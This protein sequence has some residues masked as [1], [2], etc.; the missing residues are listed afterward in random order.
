MATVTAQ[1]WQMLFHHG[2][3]LACSSFF[4][5][6]FYQQISA[7]FVDLSIPDLALGIACLVFAVFMLFRPY[8]FETRTDVFAL[9]ICGL[10]KTY[11]WLFD[12]T[13]PGDD[14]KFFFGSGLI[15]FATFTWIASVFWLG[16]SFSILPAL[17]DL[18]T[19]GPYRFVRHP[20]YLSYV[21]MDFG[22]LLSYPSLRNCVVVALALGLYTIRI[23]MEEKLLGN[24]EAYGEY[25]LRTRFRLIPF[26]Y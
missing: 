22:F 21:I 26:V 9:V 17:R 14:L 12:L 10:C 5:F 25:R 20:I 3:N 1:W 13:T 16:K 18:R 4:V 11:Y 7:S 15:V 19:T 8:A 23:S 6:V 24:L 2:C